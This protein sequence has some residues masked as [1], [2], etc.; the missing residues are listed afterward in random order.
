MNNHSD[1]D[2]E[3]VIKTVQFP[4]RIHKGNTP[5][6]VVFLNTKEVNRHGHP[7]KVPMKVYPEE[8]ALIKTA[9]FAS[10]KNYG[11]IIWVNKSLDEQI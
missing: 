7:L 2:I 8:P 5:E 10:S 3:Q 1:V 9:F 4:C 11:E 6:T